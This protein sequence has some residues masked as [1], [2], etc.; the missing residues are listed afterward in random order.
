[1]HGFPG[2]PWT[3]RG[4]HPRPRRAYERQDGV[5]PRPPPTCVRIKHGSAHKAAAAAAAWQEG[6]CEGW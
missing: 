3:E 2:R 5:H 6:K 4:E 1:M